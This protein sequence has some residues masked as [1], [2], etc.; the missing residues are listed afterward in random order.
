MLSTSKFFKINFSVFLF[1]IILGSLIF[2]FADEVRYM[3]Y[4]L[5]ISIIFSIISGL[6]YIRMNRNFKNTKDI[7][8]IG[9]SMTVSLAKLILSLGLLIP[10]YFSFCPISN[11]YLL[12]FIMTY[13]F[14]MILDTYIL[15]YE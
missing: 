13:I 10:F 1:S 12:N 9:L 5:L 2:Y 14:Y 15:S 7:V 8:V 6:I 4:Q 11:M 3:K